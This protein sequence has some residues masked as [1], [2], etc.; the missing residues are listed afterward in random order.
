LFAISRGDLG[1]GKR[2]FVIC[3]RLVG[4]SSGPKT[5]PWLQFV[6][7]RKTVELQW[8]VVEQAARLPETFQRAELALNG[9]ALTVH[10]GWFKPA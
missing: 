2:G 10:Y 6:Y 8:R 5:K 4:M 1:D 3:L 7:M 9:F